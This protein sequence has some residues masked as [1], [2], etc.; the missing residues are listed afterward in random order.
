[1]RVR[2]SKR[3]VDPPGQ[4]WVVLAEDIAQGYKFSPQENS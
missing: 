4:R 2:F 3:M 1:M